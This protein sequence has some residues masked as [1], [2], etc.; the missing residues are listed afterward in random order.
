[1]SLKLIEGTPSNGT[2]E[3]QTIT[4]S[5]SPAG[6]TFRLSKSGQR[7]GDLAH[8][9]STGD[10]QTALRALT[11]IG[12]GNVNVSGSAGD[13]YVV[14]FVGDLAKLSVSLIKVNRNQLTGGTDPEVTVESTTEGVSATLRGV[15][16]NT[17]LLSR[18]TSSMYRNT[19][20]DD[21]PVWTQIDSGTTFMTDVQLTNT[22]VVN[23]R[24]TPRT[25]VPAPGSGYAI[26]LDAVYIVVDD[27]AVAWTESDDNLEVR[28]EDTTA[29]LTVETTGFLAGGVD[30]RVQRPDHVTAGVALV[31]N[32]AIQI[33]NSGSGEFGGGDAANTMSIR[34]LYTIVPTAAFVP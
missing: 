11:S 7:T 34:S 10:M 16:A 3:I 9:I 5:G 18:T 23:L 24:G 29:I 6:G 33:K 2:N 4:I 1:M 20:T 30:N 25:L 15:P 13:T 19:G 12:A 17:L 14:E 27:T 26:L 28:Y 21:I 31:E 32:S 8:D 22:Q